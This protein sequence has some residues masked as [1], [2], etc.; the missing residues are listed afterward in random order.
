[1]D[2]CQGAL[3][4][5]NLNYQKEFSENGLVDR[6]YAPE[7]WRGNKNAYIQPKFVKSDHQF[8]SDALNFSGLVA[9][10]GTGTFAV[11]QNCV[12]ASVCMPS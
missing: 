1:M 4:T 6:K 9:G 11:F 10:Y 7:I 5:G 2:G 8:A 12:H 3:G